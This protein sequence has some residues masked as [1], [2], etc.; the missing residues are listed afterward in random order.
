MN[1]KTALLTIMI[2]V[3]PL[4]NAT[5][6]YFSNSGDDGNDCLSEENAC[7]TIA[8]M[9]TKTA[10][11]GDSFLFKRG[12]TWRLV[13]DA[14][15]TINS[16]TLGNQITY[17]AYGTGANPVFIN[18]FYANSTSNWTNVAGDV[19]RTTFTPPSERDIGIIFLDHTFTE[20]GYKV[21]DI[22]NITANKRFYYNSTVDYVYM[23]ST[24]GNPASVFENVEFAHMRNAIDT[25]GKNYFTITQWNISK[26]GRHCM[27]IRKSIGVQII[28]NTFSY[29][30]G[31]MQSYPV[32]YGNCIQFYGNA[33]NTTVMYNRIDQVYDACMSPQYSQL[34]GP[35][36]ITN[37]VWAHNIATNCAYGFE[38]FNSATG[39]TTHNILVENNTFINIGYGWYQ[40]ERDESG[41]TEGRTILLS[42][43]AVDTQN[44]TIRNNLFIN[45][46]DRH[47]NLGK[48]SSTAWKGQLPV[49]DYNFYN[50]TRSGYAMVRWNTT[51]YETLATFQVGT[52]QEPN[53]LQG[54]I[55][56][57]NGFYPSTGSSVCGTGYLGSDIGA[58]PCYTTPT[59][60]FGLWLYSD[61][62]ITILA[63]GE[64]NFLA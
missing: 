29:I 53:G 28:N 13:F 39:A 12:D 64:V 20:F 24:G 3:I 5:T 21:G 62:I 4:T 32:R 33:T 57:T 36:I 37:Q 41:S 8:E 7:K 6:Y 18:T 45:T 49:F 46:S 15:P 63:D 11:P 22:I 2:M 14:Y 43:T 54:T 9:N 55:N 38:Y 40:A 27:D 1:K 16:G 17:G 19:W 59:E 60:S 35:A 26:V 58:L 50:D 61:S 31:A 48:D 30:G 44:I 47:I 56:F 42:S 25:T 10:N 51:N 34:E 52:G 23:N